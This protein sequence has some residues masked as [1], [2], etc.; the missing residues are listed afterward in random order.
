[1][2]KQFQNEP[3]ILGLL[4]RIQEQLASLDKKVDSLI[5]RSLPRS[6]EP[7]S[8]PKPSFPQPFYAQ[9]HG[10]ERQNDF[11]QGRPMHRATC[12][13]CK[14]ECEIPFKPTGDRPVYCRECFRERKSSH[15]LYVTPENKPRIAPSGGG[16]GSHTAVD[17]PQ[18]PRKEKK[19]PAAKKSRGKKKARGKK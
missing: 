15:R 11:H 14:K 6:A 2:K 13:D 19:K 4:A 10:R 5:N 12:A 3:D 9:V 16:E 7:G 18:S 17:L 8:A 1:M